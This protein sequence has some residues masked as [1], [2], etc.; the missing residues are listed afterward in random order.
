MVNVELTR[1]RIV[2][3][4]VIACLW[5]AVELTQVSLAYSRLLEPSGWSAEAWVWSVLLWVVI[6]A[7]GT[8]ALWFT[9]RWPWMLMLPLHALLLFF[10]AVSPWAW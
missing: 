3:L 2:A 1:P 4:L 6:F 10:A 7:V 5:V 8:A 9:R